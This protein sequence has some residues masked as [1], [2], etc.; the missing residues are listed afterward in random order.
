MT[1]YPALVLSQGPTAYWRLR[2]T[3]GLV[4]VDE[5]GLHDLTYTAAVQLN[6][7]E[8]Q[9]PVSTYALNIPGSTAKASAASSSFLDFEYSDSF[10]LSFWAK[11]SGTYP[12]FGKIG[13]NSAGWWVGS[14]TTAS[15]Y[16]CIYLGDWYAANKA[17]YGF[18][19]SYG[20]V[21]VDRM[22]HWAFTYD[23][24]SSPAGIVAYVD[25]LPLSYNTTRNVPQT[26][27]KNTGVFT[28]SPGSPGG[29]WTGK[30]AEVAVFSRVLSASE[31]FAQAT[32]TPSLDAR[33]LQ[34]SQHVIRSVSRPAKNL[35]TTVSSS[36]GP[37]K[38]GGHLNPGIG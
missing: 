7:P 13:A 34:H 11:S 33:S 30:L 2:E 5:I 21:G 19:T 26:T 4:A 25:G 36:S 1:T 27:I 8:Q 18:N 24:S 6:Q 9:Y 29:N 37:A 31:V 28:I 32:W 14:M 10:S 20:T 17:I 35:I 38:G 16:M 12:I 23:G 22:H 3:S 15:I